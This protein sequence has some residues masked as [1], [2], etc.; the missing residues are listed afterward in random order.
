MGLRQSALDLSSGLFLFQV[1][2]KWASLYLGEILLIRWV[3]SPKY[4]YPGLMKYLIW[5]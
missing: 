2:F 1:S 5:G 4:I 3:F